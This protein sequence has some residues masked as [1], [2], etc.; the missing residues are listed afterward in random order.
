MAKTIH[1]RGE[2]GQTIEM[3]LPLP[4]PIA[5]RLTKGQLRRVNPDGSPYTGS[6]EPS[7][8]AGALEERGSALT[9]GETP[10]P[11][12]NARKAEWVGWA[13][14]VHGMD[15]E[16][17]EAMTKQDLADLPDQPQQ[18]ATPADVQALAAGGDGRPAEDADKAEWVGYVVRRGLLSAEDA[19]NY[20]RDDLI[21]LAS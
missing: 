3:D 12:A 4:E 14:G 8:D 7:A 2:G 1:V 5:E 9:R 13:V 17:A 15:P 18:P 16:E 6:P 19:A 11:A 10:R 21:D 20:T